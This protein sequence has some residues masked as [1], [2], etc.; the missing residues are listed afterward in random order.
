MYKVILSRCIMITKRIMGLNVSVWWHENALYYNYI[1]TPCMYGMQNLRFFNMKS[2]ISGW[3]LL[4]DVIN[5][6]KIFY[7]CVVV[8][9]IGIYIFIM[10]SHLKIF[11][12]TS[13]SSP[14]PLSV[15]RPMIQWLQII[16]VIRLKPNLLSGLG[17]FILMDKL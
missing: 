15:H 14:T 13:I 6:I 9:T 7:S 2:S 16:I 17:D 12:S 10:T 5:L 11:K 3:I 1:W 4:V 8:R